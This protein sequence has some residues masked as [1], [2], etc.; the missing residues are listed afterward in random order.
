MVLESL[1]CKYK[2]HESHAEQVKNLALIIFDKTKELEVHDMSDKKRT[3]LE[4]GANLHDIGYFVEAKS[5]NKHSSA[6]IKKEDF[7]DMDEKQKK[8]IACIARYHRGSLPKQSHATFGSLS[9]K[10]QKTIQRLAGITRLADGLDSS[11]L[12]LVKEIEFKYFPSQN[13]LWMKIIAKGSDFKLDLEAAIRKKDLFE[14]A[15]G[16]QLVLLNL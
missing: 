16:L 15:F 2:A 9:S 1:I 3:M 12:S 14:R 13:L 4:I 7:G 10:K 11:H 6:L 8:I 5:H